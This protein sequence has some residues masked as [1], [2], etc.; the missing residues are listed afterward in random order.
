MVRNAIE[1]SPAGSSVELE[2]RQFRS[3][4]GPWIAVRVRDE[5]PGIPEDELPHVTEALWR[6]S[7]AVAGKEGGLGLGLTIADRVMTAH[8]GRLAIES[9]PG[10]G[11]TVTLTWPT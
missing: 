11:T 7:A 5:G 10:K 9:P 4:N 8:G 3:E 6:G 1:L 2:L